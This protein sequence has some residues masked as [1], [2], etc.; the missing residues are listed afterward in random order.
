MRIK[1]LIVDFG[2]YDVWLYVNDKLE[3]RPPDFEPHSVTPQFVRECIIFALQNNWVEGTMNME[4]KNGIYQ[5][6]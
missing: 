4:Y 2:W 3:N 5:Q 1:F 6:K